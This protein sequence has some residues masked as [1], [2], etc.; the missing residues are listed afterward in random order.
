VVLEA[1]PLTPNGKL[2]RRALPAPA[3]TGHDARRAPRSPRE[4]ILCALFAEVLSLPEVGIEDNFFELGGHSLLATRLISRIRTTLNVDL[5]IRALF[6]SPT[7][8]ALA[9]HSDAGQSRRS[10]FDVLL[11]IRT[12]GS[13]QPIFCIHP[14]VGLSWSYSRLIG[15]IPPGHPIYGLQAR[16]LLQWHALPSGIDEMAAA[17][18][19][20]IREVQPGGSYNL[21]GW[22]FGGLVAHAMATQLQAM[23]EKV[24]MLALLDSYPPAR[25]NRSNGDDQQGKATAPSTMIDETVRKMLDGLVNGHSR[26]P[27]AAREQQAVSRVCA[28]N[29]GIVS[30]FSPKT[31]K[32]DVVLFVA[33]ESHGESSTASWRPYVAGEI[34]VHRVDCTHDDMMDAAPAA[35]IGKLLAKELARQQPFRPSYMLWRT[36]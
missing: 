5:S 11:P 21:L 13:L 15:H 33:D 35:K 29:V 3:L 25:G 19:R 7:V 26:L 4:E 20:I 17:Y 6:E 28:S 23:N 12:A 18:L 16:N 31:F 36:K 34:K 27:L 8:R 14:A 32:G 10:D 9:A 24:S 30:A 22:S 1:L 2:D